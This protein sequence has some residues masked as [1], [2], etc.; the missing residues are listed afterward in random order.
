MSPAR[1]GVVEERPPVVEQRSSPGDHA[2]SWRRNLS[3]GRIGAVYVLI[4]MVILFSIWI[5][6]TFP[7]AATVRQILNNYAITALAALA[8]IVPLSAGVFDISTPYV[9]SLSG[10]IT[11]YCIV[12]GVPLPVAVTIAIAASLAIGFVNACVVVGLRIESLIATLATGSLIQALITLVTS[13]IPINDARLT[14]G[15]SH[16]AQSGIGNVTL[17]VF[18]VLIVGLAIWC[19]QEYTT[20][21]RRLYATGF[22]K[23]ATR[24]AGVRTERLRFFT[25]LTSATLAGFTGVVLAASLGSGTPTAGTPYLLPAFAAVFLGATQFKEG[26]FNAPG[27]VLAVLIIG[28]GVTG[29]GLANAPSW[30]GSM[31]TGVILIAA[32]ALTGVQRRTTRTGRAKA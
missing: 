18:Y 16:I 17:P 10:V 31:L 11:A 23:E 1:N 21:G 30:A 22:N 32:L 14:E 20:V 5:P 3:F 28:T 7:T 27:T 15:F 12:H 13:D 25:L 24:L 19:L 6:E 9:M 29:L 2:A 26:R 4:G 8:L